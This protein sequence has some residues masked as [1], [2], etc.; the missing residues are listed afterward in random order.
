MPTVL[1]GTI[2]SSVRPMLRGSRV[3]KA[4]LI[5]LS[6]A[7]TIRS[8]GSRP[9]VT[10]RQVVIRSRPEVVF[11]YGPRDA[12]ANHVNGTRKNFHGNSYL[13]MLHSNNY[14][15]RNLTSHILHTITGRDRLYA[16]VLFVRR[17][18]KEGHF[19]LQVAIYHLSQSE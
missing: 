18:G 16:S 4:C 6:T 15:F 14:Q 17:F 19:R 9:Q 2:T 11:R 3:V 8:Q 13:F 1:R 12:R 10:A 7:N 5:R